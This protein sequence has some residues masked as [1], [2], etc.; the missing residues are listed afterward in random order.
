MKL[1][2]RTKTLSVLA[3]VC[4]A[5]VV[6]DRMEG[7]ALADA[8]LP[9]LSALDKAT[10][11]RI[12]LTRVGRTIT[13]TR[14]GDVWS[15]AQPLQ[16]EA[17][18]ARVRSLLSVFRKPVP[19]EVLIDATPDEARTEEYGLHADESVVAEF[20]SSD[21]S[22]VLSFIVGNDVP[23]G[24]SLIRLSGSEAIYRADV[25]G[26]A[27]YAREASDWRNRMVMEL[28]AT[29]VKSIEIERQTSGSLH[30][31]R[32]ASEGAQWDAGDTLRGVALAERGV[33]QQLL[34]ALA[35]T[36]TTLRS[37]EIHAEGFGEGWDAPLAHATLTLQ[38]GA[39]H[40][41]RAVESPEGKAMLVRVN[42]DTNVY[43]VARAAIDRALLPKTS[44][45]DHTVFSFPRNQLD[46]MTLVQ[47]S[48]RVRLRHDQGNNRWLVIE[49][50]HM[51]ADT[52]RAQRTLNALSNLRAESLI[53]GA[54]PEGAKLDE[55]SF[56]LEAKLLNG[57]THT[58]HMGGMAP[59]K[60]KKP[61]RYA[62]HVESGLSLVLSGPTI[63]TLRHAFL[64]E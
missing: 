38:D 59:G 53:S 14:E 18:R 64:Q 12:E 11:E 56:T 60:G 40:T 20:F 1:T 42:D 22:P 48:S 27:R 36:L 23:G 62:R 28:D 35:R 31:T 46:S 9:T 5:L 33:D 16:A 55:P 47:G 41:L 26:R 58:L 43:R 45:V 30:F 63:E 21:D 15:L 50:I 29:Q 44:F 39:T 2:S 3:G 49:P 32:A 6:V 57:T 61:A 10:V 4:L 37:S 25:G 51:D 19:I 17:D 54:A 52:R 13:L 8:A 7:P 34:D 24:A